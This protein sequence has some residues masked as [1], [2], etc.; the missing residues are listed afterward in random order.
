MVVMRVCSKCGSSDNGFYANKKAAD[1]L[2]SWCK[3]CHCADARSREKKNPEMVR[4]YHRRSRLVSASR[5][6]EY[7]RIKRVAYRAKDAV[8]A[9]EYRANNRERINANLRR[10]FK[11]NPEVNRIGARKRRAVVRGCEGTHTKAQILE[12]LSAQQGRCVY[13]KV[14]LT[15]YHADHVLPLALGGSN[16]ISNIQLL[17]PSCNQRK[18][19]KHPAEFA[20]QMGV[21]S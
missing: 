7:R 19:A 6:P 8:Y 3:K 15:K 20:K 17:C 10:Y 2:Q 1:G 13:C 21:A 11:E 4:E 18:H 5:K 16:W 12:L 14:D 9:K